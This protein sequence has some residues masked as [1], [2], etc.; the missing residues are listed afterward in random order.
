MDDIKL[1]A[2][3]EKEWENTNTDSET[4]QSRQMEGVR[5]RKMHHDNNKQETSQNER[6]RTIKQRS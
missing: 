6:N 3:I 1:F 4:I 5:H 2:K